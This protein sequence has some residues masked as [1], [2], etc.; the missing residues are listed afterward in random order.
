MYSAHAKHR[1]TTAIAGLLIAGSGLLATATA[2]FADAQPG[3]GAS[4]GTASVPA[5]GTNAVGTVAVPAAGTNAAGTVAAPAAGTNAA[6][7]TVTPA[8]AAAGTHA[9]GATMTPTLAGAEPHGQVTSHLP[10]SIREHATSN[11]RPLGSLPSGAVV[12]IRCKVV[13][14]NVDGNRLWYRLGNGRLG[15]VSARY[16][17]NL[18]PV[19]YCA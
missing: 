4:T 11:F 18:S 16:V 2:S 19:A 15:Y 17:D 14:Q 8:Q 7:T 1:A 9:T 12:S 6:P 5:A 3:T 10:L 13:G